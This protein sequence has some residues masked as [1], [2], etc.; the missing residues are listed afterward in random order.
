MCTRTWCVVEANTGIRT[1]AEFLHSRG[2]IYR[3][4]KMENIVLDDQGHVQL[5]DFGLAKWLSCG[6]RTRTVCGTLQ[7]MAPEIAAEQL[8]DHA[9]DWW[10][11]GVHTAPRAL[12]RC[13][14]CAP[15]RARHVQI[16]IRTGQRSLHTHV[17]AAE[18]G[19]NVWRRQCTVVDVDRSSEFICGHTR[20]AR[21]CTV[22]DTHANITS[23]RR[24]GSHSTPVLRHLLHGRMR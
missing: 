8:Y 16:P 14:R 6:D 1:I 22:A 24:H 23:V 11:L 19:G 2:V 18:H 17:R 13:C 15:A 21:T 5:V 10:S 12:T 4:L 20:S 3:D 9:V 7:Y